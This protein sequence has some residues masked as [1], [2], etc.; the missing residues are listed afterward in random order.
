MQRERD[1]RGNDGN[2]EILMEQ[3]PTPGRIL[4]RDIDEHT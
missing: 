1:K 4:V 3:K 2:Y